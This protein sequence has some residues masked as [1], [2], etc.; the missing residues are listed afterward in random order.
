MGQEANL[1]DDV[2]DA[3]AQLGWVVGQDVVAVD[4]DLAG[5]WLDQPVDHAKGGRFTGT[6][7]PDENTDLAGRHLEREVVDGRGCAIVRAVALGDMA[8]LNSRCRGCLS[9]WARAHARTLQQPP[10]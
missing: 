6:G 3:T 8:E 5:S 10:R 9:A 1:L 2:A 4:K 7:R